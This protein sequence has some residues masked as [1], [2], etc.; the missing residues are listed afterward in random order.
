M[1]FNLRKTVFATQYF[2]FASA[3]IIGMFASCN[4]EEESTMI[5]EPQQHRETL[6]SKD[7]KVYDQ[8]GRYYVTMRISAN[9]E[10]L[11]QENTSGVYKLI[12]N[13]Q[14]N[15]S[16]QAQSGDEL[17]SV[18]FEDDE[19]IMIDHLDNNLDQNVTS[20]SIAYTAPIPS[21][22]SRAG[23]ICKKRTYLHK[24]WEADKLYLK[25]ENGVNRFNG[26]VYYLKQYLNS[27]TFNA[28][29]T[30]DITGGVNKWTLKSG[31]GDMT[32]K[33]E[34]SEWTTCVDGYSYGM[35]VIVNTKKCADYSYTFTDLH[36]G[37]E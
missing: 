21:E 16:K 17:S 26:S 4:E 14:V 3:L 28:M 20:Y 35:A 13:E 9:T 30:S 27:T 25:N 18:D 29:T 24:G 11:L 19:V 1:L 15:E 34:V 22:N 33:G 7:L 31:F 5:S 2:V 10:V 8:S 37:A 12:V 23:W 36:C 32:G 6:F